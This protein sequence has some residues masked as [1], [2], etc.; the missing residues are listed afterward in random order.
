MTKKSRPPQ[1]G[2]KPAEPRIRPELIEELMANYKSPEDLTGPDGLLKELTAALVN[3]AMGAELDHHL[4]YA[5]GEAPPEGETNRR[6]GKRSKKLRS[7]QGTLEIEVPR[8]RESSFEPQIVPKHQ[9]H[10]DGFD[11]KILSMYARGMTT[12][13]IQAHLE[14]IYGVEVGASLISKV[15][16]AVVDEMRN[17]QQCPLECCYPIVYID[18]LVAKIRD[19]SGVRNK[20]IYLALGVAT[21]GTKSILG[22]WVQET[23]GASYWTSIL[24]E[25]RERGVEDILVLC[26]DGLKGLPDAVEA[27]FPETVFQTCIVHMIRASTRF[28]S[29]KDRKAVCADLRPIYTASTEAAAKAALERFESKW[30]EQFPMIGK[31]WRDR[32][33][34][35]SPFLSFPPEIRHAIYTTNAIEAVNR[36]LRKALKTRGHMPSEQAALK[37]LYLAIRKDGIKRSKPSPA[38]P[39]ARLQFAIYFEGRFP[40]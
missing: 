14:E 21:D 39:K 7:D 20:S 27:V 9:R 18:A 36:Q 8:D 34:E 28:V 17:W 11:D 13:E 3:R 16:D 23:E 24:A 1:T 40:A 2:K 19:K 31:S 12:R 26:A 25:L 35:V 10:F 32:W 38:W 30:G 22:M 33:E 4:G 15:T 37:L 5:P 6:N 29:W